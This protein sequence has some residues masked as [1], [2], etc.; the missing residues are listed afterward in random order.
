MLSIRHLVPLAFAAVSPLAAQTITFAEGS[1]TALT[2]LSV[3]E[4]NPVAPDT[5]LLQNVELLPIEISARTLAQS[6]DVSR[7][8]RVEQN[9]LLRVELPGGGR[10]FR[11]RR[12]GGQ[13][14]G[15]LR[16]GADGAPAVALEQPGV[17][18]LLADPFEDRIAVAADGRHAAIPLAAGGLSVV[19]LDGGV[20]A[21]TGRA[22]RLAA[23]TNLAAEARSV[24]VG[25]SVVWFQANDQ[26]FRCGLADN[27]VPVDVSPPP[28]ANAILKDEMVI[29]PDGQRVV[30]LYGL[31]NLL[32]LWTATPSSATAVLPPPP[33]RY[34]EADYLPEGPGEPAMLL[35]DAGT[36]LF[37]IENSVRD[38]LTVLDLQGVLPTL[39]ITE[40]S[41]FE[42]Y[43]GSH[44][45]PKFVADRL[46]VAIGD[47]AQMD[48]FRAELTP[49][50]GVVTNLTGTGSLLQPFPSGTLDPQQAA[51]VAGQLWIIEQQ[52]AAANLRSI[53]LTSG[54]TAVLQQGLLAAPQIGPA[55][56]GLGDVV[57]RG[58]AGDRLY[59]GASGS[60]LAALPFGLDLAPPVHGPLFAATKIAFGG[61]FAVAALYLPN[62]A[63]ALSGIETGLQQLVATP[64][65]GLVVVG[66]P[67][68]Y[69]APGVF[70]TLNRPAAAVRLCLSGAGG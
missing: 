43:I 18:A 55:T 67:P 63:L 66:N 16:I 37:Y 56:T 15:F 20:Y 51:A 23:P 27:A 30:F 28:L 64:L 47:P 50:G 65:G 62:G 29:T 31:Q 38:E 61:G 4:A 59:Q 45:L 7:A 11:Y 26:V 48:W 10:L 12:A 40:N 68:R 54:A 13:F 46:L 49:A 35:N 22:D 42:P 52:G 44:I 53:D 19:R 21:S 17:G 5:V 39:Q 33:S 8:R 2:I 6:G 3:P 60:L 14:W 32:Q 9:G 41:I 57:V 25:D 69:L 1:A 34:E 58:S 24:L 70:A 36:R